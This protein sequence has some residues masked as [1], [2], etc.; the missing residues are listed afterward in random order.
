MLRFSVLFARIV[1][2]FIVGIGPLSSPPR[3]T[4][5]ASRLAMKFSK[6]P[7][8]GQAGPSWF[9]IAPCQL[10]LSQT[11]LQINLTFI[12][13]R[14]E[15]VVLVVNHIGKVG[16]FSIKPSSLTSAHGELSS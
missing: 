13:S 2:L 7:E 12:R 3:M 8:Y 5:S 11:G 1:A 9:P 15:V 14:L 4:L 10:I 16:L 6:L